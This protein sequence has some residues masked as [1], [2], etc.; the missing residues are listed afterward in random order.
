MVVSVCASSVLKLGA[1]SCRFGEFGVVEDCEMAALVIVSGEIT[2]LLL[3]L[4]P[5][6]TGT[7]AV[8]SKER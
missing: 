8:H 6:D 3:R 1:I 5:S 7:R 4:V 2:L